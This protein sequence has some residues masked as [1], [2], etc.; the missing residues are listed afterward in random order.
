MNYKKLVLTSI[1]GLSLIAL[2][3]CE[4]EKNSPSLG[5]G[6]FNLSVKTNSEVIPVLRSTVA[7]NSATPEPED[8]AIKLI[9][10]D[11]SFS[12]NWSTIDNIPPDGKYDIGNYTIQA[13]YGSVEEEGF[14]TP[15]YCG[16]TQFTIKDRETTP[17]EILCTLGHVK[18]TLQYTEAFTNYFADYQTTVTTPLG[19]E[20]LFA[21]NEKRDA[22]VAPGNISMKMTLT[23]PNGITATFA[24]SKII[25]ATARQHYIVT[26]DVSESTGATTL[27]IVFDN[28]TQVEPITINVS[29]EAMVAP[30]PS[31]ALEGVTAGGSIE[32]QECEYPQ[33]TLGATVVA[34]GG[35]AS[36]TLT[37]SS[38]YLQSLGFPA[39][40]ELSQITGEQL[41]L[42]NELGLE[43]KGFGENRDQ[44]AFV[45][46]TALASVL[47]ITPNG[48]DTHTF[49]LTARDSNGKVSD[50]VT[51]SIK[52]TP[53]TLALD[54]IGNVMM[55]STHIDLPATFNGKETSRLKVLCDNGQGM[56]EVPYTIENHTGD[57]YTLRAGVNVENQPLT[58]QLVYAGNR[59]TDTR[60]AGIDV[61]QYTIYC[62]DYDIWATR[63]VVNITAADATY[64]E[65]IEKYIRFYTNEG[66]AWNEMN[67]EKT[68]RGY[69]LTGLKGATT[70]TLKGS[71]LDDQSDLH[72]NEALEITTEAM[73][74]LPN[75][76][77]ES[78]TQWFSQ[79]INKGGK[80]YT[81][82][83]TTK[84]ET[85]SLSSSNPDGW[86]TV[87]TK[88]VPTSPATANTWYMVPSTLPSTGISGKAAL[89][90]NVAWDNNGSTPPAG[91]WGSSQSLSSL[92]APSI[93]NRSAGKM[94]LGSYSYNHAS[95]AEVYNEGIAFTSR[96]SKLT[97]YYKYVAKGGDK[98]G[99]VTVTVEHRTPAGS[100]VT[101]ATQTIA[102]TPASSYTYFEVSLPYTNQDY[103]AT[104]INVM[105]A[106]SNHAS[107]SQSAES[108]GIATE[109]ILSEAVSLGSELYIDNISLSY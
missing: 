45:N 43:V 26:F 15:Y 55:G 50:P 108:A 89:V 44:M 27:T 46:F 66:G 48:E 38:P 32:L 37:T 75:G 8:F 61:P 76:D 97:G 51:F 52:N 87:N 88:T 86:A 35:V 60:T 41:A 74:T 3:S 90:R 58:L 80:Y 62:N 49:T 33:S 102:L 73:T 19:N 83:I 47:Q 28:E 105:F 12:K 5:E 99:V 20:I 14:N 25:N 23:K 70:Y 42:I 29:D 59:T 40:M 17:V 69:N 39:V 78:W 67:L 84:Q 63:A 94:F 31:I 96:P 95:G 10:E 101:L 2:S 21:R 13:T 24:P 98:N 79:T 53:L 71:C 22:Y 7:Q 16:E 30:A 72:N 65:A 82:I 4:Q 56:K 64:Q 77:F 109:D 34:R 100:T 93:A 54:N 6:S 92:D 91:R 9:S 1:L 107:N 11:G 36:G 81:N 18:L 68:S 85:Q 57:Q 106:S 103:K 104:H